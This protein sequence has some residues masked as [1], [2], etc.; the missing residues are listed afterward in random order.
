MGHHT[1]S[2]FKFADL[3]SSDLRIS[4]VF[5]SF[6]ASHVVNASQSSSTIGPPVPLLVRR[7]PRG[8]RK[9]VLSS[10]AVSHENNMLLAIA[11]LL[12]LSVSAQAAKYDHYEP[13]YNNY[14]PSYSRDVHYEEPSYTY[15]PRSTYRYKRSTGD[16][17]R[18][19]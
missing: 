2:S 15:E 3:I 5:A 18:S 4:P 9:S 7:S 13:S 17:G 16:E 19:V 1:S 12:V 8:Q 6:A 11:V 14:E 10:S